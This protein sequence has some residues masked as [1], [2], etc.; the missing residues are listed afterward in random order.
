MIS[1]VYAI[2]QNGVI[3]K[4]GG[5]PWHVPSD[6]KHFK[7][8]TTGKPVVMGR[9]TWESLPK[10]PLP[11]RQNIVVSRNAGF[12]A[13][14]AEVV[15][16]ISDAIIKGGLAPEICVIGGAELFKAAMPHASRIY[17]TRILAD[18]SGDTFMPELSASEWR[19]VAR[20]AHAKGEKDSAVFETITYER[21]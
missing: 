8:V 11:G 6:L 20:T 1:L 15:G 2:S 9:K 18:V 19:E 7:A 10:R 4:D 14:G 3:G 13:E 12:V 5:L 16:T 21:R 17:L